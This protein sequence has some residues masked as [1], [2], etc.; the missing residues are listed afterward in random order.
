VNVKRI[1]SDDGARPDTPHQIIFCDELTTREGQG[2]DDL[3][4]ALP[5]DD[6]CAARPKLTPA[7]VYLPGVACIDQIWRCSGHCA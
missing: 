5:E 1:F 7:E 3:E 4:C 6:R 2:L